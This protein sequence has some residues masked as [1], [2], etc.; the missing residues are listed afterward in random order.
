MSTLPKLRWG[1]IGVGR[2]TRQYL[3]PA[4]SRSAH[5]E[6]T[7]L[8]TSNPDS[9]KRFSAPWG[10]PAIYDSLDALL[11]ARAVDAVLI[12]TPT[13]AHHGQALAAIAAGIHVLCEK[14]L[15]S[16]SSLAAEMV[17]A[18]ERAGVLLGTGFNLRHNQVHRRAR[19]IIRSGKIGDVRFAS[20]RYAHRTSPIPR[21]TA[22][23]T[24]EIPPVG[25]W[26]RDPAIA[27]G[28]A[29]ASTGSHAIDILRFLTDDDIT[30]VNA[31]ADARPPAEI[32]LNA[33]AQLTS[34]AIAQ[35]HAGE[36]PLPANEIAISGT[37]GTVTCVGS[38]GNLGTGTLTVTTASGTE[39]WEAP[40]HDVYIGECDSFA[41]A[42]RERSV[43]D[44]SGV[45]GLRSQQVIDAVYE[46][47]ATGALTA[48]AGAAHEEE[49]R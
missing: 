36:L 26:R 19:D 2:H 37:L 25:A 30:H 3:I 17:G 6:L 44:A 38:V 28:G 24:D 42:V 10:E 15:A 39:T 4:I 7:A 35:I 49:G 46:A 27:G 43:P 22:V 33:S 32:V 45:D 41:L 13:S 5:G 11:A 1:V 40:T 48:V 12:C 47:A 8:V 18:A 14:P 21:P 16:T 9:A 29:F 23:S 20:V 34:G 31:I